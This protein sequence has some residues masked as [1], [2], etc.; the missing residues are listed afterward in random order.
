MLTTICSRILLNTRA[1]L[2]KAQSKDAD[3]E[4]NH[5]PSPPAGYG[6]A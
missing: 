3:Y 4:L 6:G 1:E 2:T 5:A